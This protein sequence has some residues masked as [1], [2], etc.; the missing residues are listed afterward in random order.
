[1]N[2]PNGHFIGVDFNK[3]HIDK[4]KNDANFIGLKI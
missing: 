1:M 2:N 3:E 4:A